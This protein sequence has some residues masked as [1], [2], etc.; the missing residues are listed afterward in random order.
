MFKEEPTHPLLPPERKATL[1]LGQRELSLISLLVIGV[2]VLALGFAGVRLAQNFK[3]R[4]DIV[5]AQS[6]LH[7][8]YIAMHGYSLDWDN[9]LPHADQW[10][11]E[12]AGYLSAPPDTPGGKLSYLHGSGDGETIGYVY[13]DLASEYNLDDHKDAHKLTVDP[14]RVVLLIERPG[15]PLNAHV[16]IPVQNN[17]QAEDALLKELAFPHYADDPKGATTVILYA[18]GNVITKTR[19]DFKP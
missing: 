17:E 4:R 18:N 10:A 8:L 19:Q 1:R 9:K 15:A 3:S 7:A 14:S 13:N 12:A 5:I 16:S 2:I 6:N 11:E